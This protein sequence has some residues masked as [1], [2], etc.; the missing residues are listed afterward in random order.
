MRN[1]LRLPV[2]LFAL[3]P[4]LGSAQRPNLIIPQ[5]H[6]IYLSQIQFS[7][8]GK[9]IYTTTIDG[10]TKIWDAVTGHLFHTIN[11]NPSFIVPFTLDPR[12]KISAI[13]GEDFLAQIWDLRNGEQVKVLPGDYSLSLQ[14]AI[15]PDGST[16]LYG[17]ETGVIEAKSLLNGQLLATKKRH[18]KEVLKIAYSNNG[19]YIYSLGEKDTLKVW[20]AQNWELVAQIGGL[21][22]DDLNV[23]FLNKNVQI[24]FGARSGKVYLWDF[25]TQKIQNLEGHQS[26]LMNLNT[27]GNSQ[28]VL[29]NDEEYTARLWD[30]KNKE[31]VFTIQDS[32]LISTQVSKN[33]QYMIGGFENGILKC[34][35]TQNQQ[36]L[37]TQQAHD[38]EL[39][40]L[41]FSPDG[42]YLISGSANEEGSNAV[43]LWEV[44][45]GRQVQKFDGFSKMVE[46]LAIAPNQRYLIAGRSDG[47]IQIWDHGSGQLLQSIPAH[48]GAIKSINISTDG[49]QF[50]SAGDDL[51]VKI[52]DLSNF[53]L[54]Q[55]LKGPE[56]RIRSVQ[57]SPDQQVL[58]SIGGDQQAFVWDLKNKETFRIGNP[59]SS[60]RSFEFSPDS[61][62]VITTSFDGV[63][64]IWDLQNKVLLRS[65]SHSASP[66]KAAVFSQ[67]GR[68][69]ITV[70][71]DGT[72]KYWD[73]SS[74]RVVKTMAT[75]MDFMNIAVISKDRTLLYMSDQDARSKVWDLQSG[76]LKYTFSGHSKEVVDAKLSSDQTLLITSS[77]DNTLKYRDLKTGEEKGTLVSLGDKDWALTSPNGLFDASNAA[78][79]TMHYV[80]NDQ[81]RWES[82]DIQQLKTRYYEPGLLAKITGFSNESI[83]PVSV[84][85]EVA[86]YPEILNYEIKNDQLKIKM[87]PRSGGLGKLPIFINGKEIISDANP[88]PR[89]ENTQRAEQIQFD[90]KPYQ[91]YLLKHP[92][93]T[94]YVQFVSYNEGGWLKSKIYQLAYQFAQARGNNNSSNNAWVGQLDPKLYVVCIGT[95]DYNGQQLDLKYADQDATL[96]ARSMATVGS[97]LFSNGDSL[98]VH[99]LTTAGEDSTGLEGTTVNWLFATKNNI[100]ATLKGIQ[101]RAKAEDILMVYFSGHGVTY[102]S[103]EQSQFHYLTQGIGSE[104]LSDEVVRNAY[105][106][107]SNELTAW[108]NAVPALKQVLIIDACSS[109]Q[110]VNNLSTSSKSTASSQVR[111][112]DRMQ[113]RT[114]M[115]VLSGSAADKVS[116]EASAY[117]QGLLTYALLQGMR[118]LATRK[119]VGGDAVDVMQLFQYARDEVPR[120]AATISG[121]QAPMLGFPNRAASFD[122]GLLDDNAKAKLP[123]TSAKPIMIRSTFLNQNTIRDDLQL[124]KK[125]N[126]AFRKESEKGRNA[127]LIFV[128]VE[129]YPEA[130][131]LG[132]L[133]T[134]ENTNIQLKLKLLQAD[135]SIDIEIRATDNADRL[136]K[137]ILRAVYREIK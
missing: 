137:M 69:A 7:E 99:C 77:Y 80:I 19:K 17:D 117:G 86:L 98:E 28:Y 65:L 58:M 89:G 129:S 136:V 116:Y 114:G 16:F 124:S 104:D 21:K 54:L 67:S 12:S 59:R 101:K 85:E 115:F 43:F 11:G 82:I 95:S 135:K 87:K 30:L 62:L 106:I 42:Q 20:Q 13:G 78:M 57:F 18:A 96:M 131:N 66:L 130:Y 122:I 111:A 119:T 92:D 29:S 41:Q 109:G 121:I 47:R 128:D 15:S 123:F 31:L 74:G 81:N 63:A 9:L 50:I 36:L 33:G 113:D 100:Q 112:I 52:W 51:D 70:S 1:R 72:T 102:G 35:N 53:K 133:Y 55:V 127:N 38:T 37:W 10:S 108:I 110:I 44:K 6:S 103:S 39:N 84:F 132:G 73:L 64:Q 8:D 88:L 91:K 4:F 90:L 26:P 120:L 134:L 45:S 46:S 76:Q 34:W 97:T 25:L 93:S 40:L 125:L 5:S 49:R 32:G 48:K 105:T 71:G 2:L 27:S 24:V 23:H 22:I 83:R 79:N 60:Y 61:K 68:M 118:G 107:S 56:N 94:N 75:P 3:L 126:E 14:F